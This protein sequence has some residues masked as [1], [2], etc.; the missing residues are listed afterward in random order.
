MCVFLAGNFSPTDPALEL[1]KIG[2]PSVLVVA[3]WIVAYILQNRMAHSLQSR[4]DIRDG[5]TLLKSTIKNFNECYIEYCTNIDKSYLAV[6][7]TSDFDAISKDVLRAAKSLPIDSSRIMGMLV[8]ISMSL[9]GGDFQ[10]KRRGKKDL[11]DSNF[12]RSADKFN[13]ILAILEDGYHEKYED[14]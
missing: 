14:A 3:G 4:K 5:L 8:E 2:L 6:R 11:L 13:L 7:I 9:T 12:A 10:T 1:L